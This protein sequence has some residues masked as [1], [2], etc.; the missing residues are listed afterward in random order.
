MAAPTVMNLSLHKGS[1][2]VRIFK[3]ALRGAVLLSINIHLIKKLSLLAV[4][5]L[6]FQFSLPPQNTSAWPGMIF[7]LDGFDLRYAVPCAEAAKSHLQNHLSPMTFSTSNWS[8]GEIQQFMTTTGAVFYE[9]SHGNYYGFL[10]GDAG[11]NVM[12]PKWFVYPDDIAAWGPTHLVYL[13]SCESGDTTQLVGGAQ[14]FFGWK[15][16]VMDDR[17]NVGYVNT[18]FTAFADQGKTAADS[19]LYAQTSTGLHNGVLYGE[20]SARLDPPSITYPAGWNL[21]AGPAG[22]VFPV[23]LKACASGDLVDAGSATTNGQGYAAYFSQSTAVQQSGS[24]GLSNLNGEY[25]LAQGWNFVGN[26]MTG[27]AVITLSEGLFAYRLVGSGWQAVSSGEV[28][29]PGS[30]LL[31]GAMAN[32]MTI[33]LT[34]SSVSQ[35]QAR[36]ETGDI[37]KSTAVSRAQAAREALGLQAPAASGAILTRDSVTGEKVWLVEFGEDQVEVD[38]HSGEVALIFNSQEGKM[39]AQGGEPIS[40]D[41]A[42]ELASAYTE[43]IAASGGQ[44]IAAE[45]SGT[46]GPPEVNLSDTSPGLRW[47][48]RFPR[49]L[50]GFPY[51][52]D[53]LIV[54][55][56]AK[57]GN[58]EGYSRHFSSETCP[59]EV[60][61]SE[62]TAVSSA[63]AT[64]QAWGVAN[65]TLKGVS[66]KIVPPNY[67]WS[68][69]P[70]TSLVRESRL[71][72]EV[73]FSCRTAFG[74]DKVVWVDAGSGEQIGGYQSK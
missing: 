34:A 55:I 10:C 67:Y 23:P 33:T 51:S 18:F 39:T 45:K 22:T 27:P 58:L 37:E 63:T 59:T 8:K 53:G 36:V 35:L 52:Y 49:Q 9:N 11:A 60:K 71:A 47:Q 56:D 26:S 7:G 17:S 32:G 57:N 48:V 69:S 42:V 6:V 14:T 30:A 24:K 25:S 44:A 50:N 72:Y 54:I 13:D 62:A 21:V 16:Y 12:N 15:G 66:L 61:I 1:L 74:Q 5:V 4:L 70:V 28:M 73:R 29:P 38:S 31:V 68:S 64:L 65:P 2:S 20:T 40:S 43:G 41:Q 46:L 19:L 3:S